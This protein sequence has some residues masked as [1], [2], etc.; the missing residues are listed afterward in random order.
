MFI[1]RFNL[2]KTEWLDVVFDDRNKEYGA[3]NLRQTYSSNMVRAML[4]T[5]SGV[6][7]I[8]GSTLLFRTH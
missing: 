1:S 4:I 2:Y 8:F 5:F 6:A 3:Y 7:L